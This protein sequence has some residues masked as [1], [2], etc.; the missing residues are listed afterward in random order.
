VEFEKQ[1][2]PIRPEVIRG[3]PR[4]LTVCISLWGFQLKFPEDTL[5]HDIVE[6][7]EAVRAADSQLKEYE[8]LPH[9]QLRNKQAEIQALLRKRFFTARSTL[10]GCFNLVEAYLNGLAWDFFQSKETSE[11]SNRQK[12]LLSDSFSTSIREKLLKYPELIT[13]RALWSSEDPDVVGFLEIVKP[14]R[15]SL[16]HPSPFSAPEK[17][18]G[19]DKLRLLYRIETD[20]ANMTVEITARLLERIYRHT[21]QDAVQLPRWMDQIASVA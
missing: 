8:N 21:D 1:F 17:F 18:G 10:I 6:A 4:H 7:I 5:S 14:Y 3:G 9:L 2:S 16:V 13:G 12:K 19:H 11:L 15:D 20:T